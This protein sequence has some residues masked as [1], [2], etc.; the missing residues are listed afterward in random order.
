L[1]KFISDSTE[2]TD[3]H[4]DYKPHITLAYV[5]AGEGAKYAGDDSLEGIPLSF[6]TLIF[7][8][9]DKERTEIP[10]A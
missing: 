3:S 2:C 1:N 10:L 5:K 9:K 8:G 7:S 4:P 6:D